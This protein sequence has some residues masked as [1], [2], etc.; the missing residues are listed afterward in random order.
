[1]ATRHRRD[2]SDSLDRELIDLFD[3]AIQQFRAH[4]KHVSLIA[5]GG[6]G[7]GELSPG[8]DLDIVILH[9]GRIDKLSEIVNAIL[10]PLWDSGRAVDHAVRTPDEMKET[11][12]SDVKVM[13]GALD[14]RIIAGDRV[15]AGKVIVEMSTLFRR[16]VMKY[17]PQ[18]RDVARE[19]H[20]RQGELAYLLEPDLKEARGGLRDVTL[21]RAIAG[22]SL[23][24]VPLDRIASAEATL[25]NVRDALHEV[26][27]RNKDVLLF[28]EQDKVAEQ[29]LY[30][31]ADALMADVA[32]SARTIDY[33]L[34][35]MWHRI[36]QV[37]SG[38]LIRLF[39]DKRDLQ[40]VNHVGL[41][42]KSNELMIADEYQISN[43]PVIGLR[44]AATAA[45][46]GVPLSIDSCNRLAREMIDLPNPWPKNARDELVTLIGA[47]NSMAQVWE[48]LEQEG[49]I[50]RWFPEWNHLRSLPQRNVLH[51]HTVDRHMVETAIKAAAL[52]RS[53][54][55]PDL[56]LVAALFHDLGKGFAGKDHSEFG[57]EL[58][59]P[60]ARRMGFD[61][62][63][64]EVLTLLVK[65]HLLISAIATR[66]DLDDPATIT[67]VNSL[68]PNA[69]T[70]ELLHS[71][72]I[73]DGEATGKTAWSEWKATLV[74]NLVAKCRAAM[75]GIPPAP[76]LNLS[77]DDIK[78][79]ESGEL[80]VSLRP[81]DDDFIIDIVIPDRTGV[82]ALVAGVLSAM[83]CDV[84]TA[85]TRSYAQSAVMRWNVVV[86]EYIS[87][88]TESTLKSLLTEAL[89]GKFNI[90]ARIAE[91]IQ[92]FRLLPG[93][94]VPPPVVE[95]L[96]DAATGATVLEVR[97][98][99]RPG[100][101][102]SIASEITAANVEIKAA[103]VSTL[104]A[105]ALDSLYITE[106]DGHALTTERAHQIAT[107][108]QAKLQ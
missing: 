3:A 64:T 9:D 72:S 29:L 107:E 55:R 45:Q 73:A 36:D 52:T 90:E 19:R 13:M 65:H 89:N 86:D 57:A 59:E 23:V 58:M 37:K 56:L 75:S 32:R 91:R 49:V 70:L 101:L 38:K 78:R 61:R 97:M 74:R 1:M 42:L 4:E 98:H 41:Y 87:P 27:G 66:R 93:I 71:L 12:L 106:L 40:S 104:G 81:G 69:E 76:Q 6:Y 53:V 39:K 7:R 22:S 92:N 5:V 30:S 80:H 96:N 82:L 50:S 34:E 94:P 14:A 17:V 60:L 16:R 31:D 77:A 11:A 44:A 48:V 2:R 18:L 84:R 108:L 105:E 99:D 43:D 95:V 51:R 54:H 20:Q 21:I 15:F 85:R 35:L 102:Y 100:L 79:A 88:P 46:L 67:A 28:T 62:E 26:S 10:Y 68:I 103:I 63:D 25:L 33:V 83:R 8:S 24:K 47:G